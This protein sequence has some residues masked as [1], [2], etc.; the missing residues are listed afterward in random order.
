MY[1][2]PVSNVSL[3]LHPAPSRQGQRIPQ[4]MLTE[5]LQLPLDVTWRTLKD[6]V[7]TVCTVDYVEVFPEST[8][9]WV[10]VEGRENFKAAFGMENE[11]RSS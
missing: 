4:A 2:I 6:F 3:S 7:R 11:P 10:R 9:G 5:C 8:S 1:H